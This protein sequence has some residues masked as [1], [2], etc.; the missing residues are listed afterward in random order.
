MRL[1]YTAARAEHLRRFAPILQG[2]VGK[3][4]PP[5]LRAA[6]RAPERREA[7]LVALVDVR[8]GRQQHLRD[9][10]SAEERRPAKRARVVLEIE[11]RHIGAILE[12]KARRVDLAELGGDVERIGAARVGLAARVRERRILLQQP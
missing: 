11:Q 9:F 8:A 10:G 4:L 5:S 7:V 1:L 3:P 12:E 2:R 6:Y